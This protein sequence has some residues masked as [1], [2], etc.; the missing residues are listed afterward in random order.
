MGAVIPDNIASI[1]VTAL[2]NLA[3]DIDKGALVTIDQRKTRVS[4]LPL[5]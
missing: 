3:D 2:Q 4:L 5:K 1:V